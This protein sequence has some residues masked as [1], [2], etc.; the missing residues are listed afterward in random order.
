MSNR[1]YNILFHTHT[2]SG[3][4]ISVAL[5]VIFFAGSFSFFRDEMISWER[6]EPMQESSLAEAD[7]NGMMEALGQDY[8]TYSRD[9]TFKQYFEE[10]RISVSL[11]APKDTSIHEPKG[12]GGG[13][14]YMH[15]DDF[16]TYDYA[17]NYS[18]GEFLYRLHFF[19]QLNLY[20][21]SGYLIAGLVAFFFL[22]AIITGVL[23]HWKKI[24]SNFYVFRPRASLKNL[25]TDAHTA[26]GIIGLP[27]QFVY[28]VSGA[29]L[30]IG[31]AVMSPPVLSLMYNGETDK[32]YEDFGLGVKEFPLA[33]KKT[34]PIDLNSFVEKTQQRWPGL[35][36][37]SVSLHNYGDAGMH[38]VVSGFPQFSEAFTGVGELV[39]HATSGEIVSAKDPVTGSSYLDAARGV[40]DRLH[41]GDF[42]GVGL[43]VVY[44]I[45]GIISCFVILS[46]ILIWLVARDKKHIAE[47]K[48]KF[49]AWIGWIFLAV[50][51]SMYP[52]TAFTFVAVKL[53]V[54]EFDTTRMT[55]IY[56]IFFY[57]WLLLIVLFTFRRD[58]FITNKYSL[59]LG[60]V[61]GFLVPV[62]NGVISGNWIWRTLSEG[63]YDIFLID[64]FWLVLSVITFCIAIG[65]KRKG[66]NSHLQAPLK[67]AGNDHP[68]KAAVTG[69]VV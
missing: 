44:F 14:F 68:A 66:E 46:G 7:L 56:Q 15:T 50:C 20:G 4:F 41:F 12:G 9:I 28:A 11:T 36:I 1:V 39:F 37:E 54:Q 69:Q 49:N 25:W 62:A 40:I 17:S 22:F 19:A 45:L 8:D 18:I 38:V 23:V 32:M 60:S 34:G 13:F 24:V 57:S 5:F 51:L 63:Y 21:T 27:F 10:K 58:N 64:A 16:S 48:R 55:A 42:G 6:N 3:L 59:L 30:I 53:F 2:I 61:L 26:L 31:A 29:F 35:Q 52:V 43:K 65:L 47:K 67:N 33:L